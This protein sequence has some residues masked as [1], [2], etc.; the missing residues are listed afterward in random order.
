MRSGRRNRPSPSVTATNVLPD[1]SLMA[2]TV[3]PGST[4]PVESVIVPVTVASCAYDAPGRA[5]TIAIA[6][7]HRICRY[8]TDCLLGSLR[9]RQTESGPCQARQKRDRRR[10]ERN[11]KESRRVK[12]TWMNWNRLVVLCISPARQGVNAFFHAFFHAFFRLEGTGADWPRK[13]A[14][15][16]V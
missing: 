9:C 6:R 12:S 7:T 15:A 8:M 3:T 11:K 2:V 5:R 10:A 13:S 1:S 16:G 14:P 4:P